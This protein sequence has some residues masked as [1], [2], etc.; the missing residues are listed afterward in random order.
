MVFHRGLSDSE[1]PQVYWTLLR[2]VAD[3]SNAVVWM[4]STCLLISKSPSSLAI[5]WGSFQGY[6]LQL[7][8]PSSA[9]SFCSLAKSFHFFFAFTLWSIRME[10]SHIRQFF[11]C[12]FFFYYLLGCSSGRNFVIRLY[13][14]IPENFVL[15][16]LW[17]RFWFVHIPLV[18]MV[19]F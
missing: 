13:L 18:H 3:F 11:F 9:C 16:I 4:V 7:E 17:D 15:P 6:Q 10:K 19:K 8:S 2:I 14:K 1:S 5:L 12:F